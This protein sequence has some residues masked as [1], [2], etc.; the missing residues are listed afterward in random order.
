MLES[1]T[2]ATSPMFTTVLGACTKRLVY[3]RFR[4]SRSK[5]TLLAA[6]AGFVDVSVTVDGYA[7]QPCEKIQFD[8]VR[9]IRRADFSAFRAFDLLS[10]RGHVSPDDL[11][12]HMREVRE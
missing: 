12:V 2:R 11:Y 7:G 6:Y 3:L 9:I 1:A 4:T 5:A 8:M 10:K